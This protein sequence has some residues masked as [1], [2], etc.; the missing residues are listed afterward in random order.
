MLLVMLFIKKCVVRM[1]YEYV[2][3]TEVEGSRLISGLRK[4]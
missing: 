4:H 3:R 2:N 1:Q